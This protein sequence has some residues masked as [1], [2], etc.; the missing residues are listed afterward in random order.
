MISNGIDLKINW[1]KDT[2]DK[3]NHL[4]YRGAKKV[5]KYLGNYLKKTGLLE[6]HRKDSKYES[7]DRAYDI[8]IKSF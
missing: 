1:K 7:W 3:G 5:T 4:N 6:D 8:Y 2:K